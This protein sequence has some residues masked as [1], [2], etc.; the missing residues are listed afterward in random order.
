MLRDH[1]QSANVTHLPLEHKPQ[2]KSS[3]FSYLLLPF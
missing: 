1:M 2:Y 3:K